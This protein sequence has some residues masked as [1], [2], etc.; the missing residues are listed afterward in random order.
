M[1]LTHHREKRAQQ[2]YDTLGMPTRAL[3]KSDKTEI[4]QKSDL[5]MV[6]H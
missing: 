5:N 1:P 4:N 6:D 2:N 3:K